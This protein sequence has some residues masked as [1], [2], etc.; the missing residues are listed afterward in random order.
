MSTE[1]SELDAL[2]KDI[3]AGRP[4]K[5]TP[6]RAALVKEAHEA[7]ERRKADPEPVEEWANRLAG[8]VAGADD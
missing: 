6:E 1:D 7:N 8:S 3:A 5:M 2:L 4:P